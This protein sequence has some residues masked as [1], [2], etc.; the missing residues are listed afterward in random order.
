MYFEG[1]DATVYVAQF[2]S[3]SVSLDAAGLVLH[4]DVQELSA[5]DSFMHVAFE[6]SKA[7][8]VSARLGASC[9]VV[10]TI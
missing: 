4:Q 3:S 6:F 1:N 10:T 7:Q 5:S 2:V 8:L 9:F